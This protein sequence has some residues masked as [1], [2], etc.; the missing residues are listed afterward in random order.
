MA[1]SAIAISLPGT[2]AEARSLALVPAA[3][4]FPHVLVLSGVGRLGGPWSSIAAC[5]E[6]VTTVVS[7]AVI[8][9]LQFGAGLVAG[10]CLVVLGGVAGPIVASRRGVLAAAPAPEPALLEPE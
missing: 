10:G 8:L 7:A 9:G 3:T 6:V 4:I 2:G 5:L 1:N